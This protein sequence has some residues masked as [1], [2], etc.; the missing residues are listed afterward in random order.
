MLKIVGSILI[1][2]CSA[3]LGMAGS[4]DLKKHCMELRILK[5]AV[6]MLRG[7]IKYSKAPLPEAFGA[8]AARVASPFGEFFLNL[9]RELGLQDGRS[10]SQLWREG[11]KQELRTTCLSR[12]EKERLQQLGEGLGYLDLE[13]QLST[14]QLYLEQLD[15]D[16]ARAQEE[17]RTKQ[18]LYRS[19]GVAGGIFLVILL[20]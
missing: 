19:L 15:G 6:Y 10:L 4:Q 9:E 3:G 13:M 20:V 11:V 12:E 7:E 2:C 16:I 14:I 5:Q 17:I 8:L 1:L 18:K